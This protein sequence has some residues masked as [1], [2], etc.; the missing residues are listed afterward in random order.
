[1]CDPLSKL[2]S[3]ML[4]PFEQSRTATRVNERDS[5]DK[6]ISKDETMTTNSPQASAK[7]YTFPARGR[8]ALDD[9]RD[10][11]K[12]AIN[13]TLPRFAKLAVGGAWY[14]EQAIQDAQRS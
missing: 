10:D 14:H 5:N 9:K 3:A 4:Y 1:M 11:A 12:P 13:V 6:Q 8:F 7:V 2:R